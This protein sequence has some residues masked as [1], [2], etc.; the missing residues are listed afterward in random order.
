ME[1]IKKD[2]NR[3]SRDENYTVRYENTIDGINNNNKILLI[4]KKEVKKGEEGPRTEEM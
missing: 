1:D 4:P 2:P 3:S